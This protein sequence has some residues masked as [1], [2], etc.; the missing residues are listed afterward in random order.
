MSVGTHSEQA[1][2][3]KRKKQKVGYFGE[4]CGEKRDGMGHLVAKRKYKQEKHKS[5]CTFKNIHRQQAPR[6]P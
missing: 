2:P 1:I 5:K 3:A 6:V 4:G